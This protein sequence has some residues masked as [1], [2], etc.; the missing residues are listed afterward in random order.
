MKA[1][2]KGKSSRKKVE[3]VV[4]NNKS[5]KGGGGKSSK[6][7]SG[8]QFPDD[9]EVGEYNGY[10]MLNFT[11]NKEGGFGTQMGLSKIRAVLENLEA[12]KAFSESNGVTCDPD[13]VE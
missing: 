9:P 12:C 3:Q 10:P 8:N 2:I 7:Y 5:S 4:R 6:E 1:L 13:E 11:P